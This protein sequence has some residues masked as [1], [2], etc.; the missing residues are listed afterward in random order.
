MR[1]IENRV[2]ERKLG[3]KRDEYTGKWRKLHNWELNDAYS[4]QNIIRMNISRRMR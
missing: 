2:L 1:G 4:L 3:L